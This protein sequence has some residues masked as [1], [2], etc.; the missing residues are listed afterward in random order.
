MKATEDLEY[1][2]WSDRAAGDELAQKRISAARRFRAI[3]HR[4]VDKAGTGQA[5]EIS[6]SLVRA[7]DSAPANNQDSGLTRA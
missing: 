7:D 2:P 4:N 5:I 3:E 1:G 6:R